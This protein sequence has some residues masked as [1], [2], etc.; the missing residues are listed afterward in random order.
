MAA[1]RDGDRLEVNAYNPGDDPELVA[2]PAD[3]TMVRI[4]ASTK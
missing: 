1:T 4:S 3:K 2:A